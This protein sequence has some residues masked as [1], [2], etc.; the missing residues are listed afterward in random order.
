M[1]GSIAIKSDLLWNAS[2]LDRL[3]EE[4]LGCS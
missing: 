3:R 1:R 4:A 2:L